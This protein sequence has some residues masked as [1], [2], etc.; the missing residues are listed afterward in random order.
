[1]SVREAGGQVP[2]VAVIPGVRLMT[3]RGTGRVVASLIFRV[4]KRR[5][6]GR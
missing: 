1:M 3:A 4:S 6:T 2:G 5:L